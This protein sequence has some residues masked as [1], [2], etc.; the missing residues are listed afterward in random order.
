MMSTEQHAQAA[1][2]AIEALDERT[3]LEINEKIAVLKTAASLLENTMV[4]QAH[5]QA[6]FNVVNPK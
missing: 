5:A 1:A 2:F 6:L 3:K 4:A